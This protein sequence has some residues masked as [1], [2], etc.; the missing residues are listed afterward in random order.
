[1][2]LCSTRMRGGVYT[3]SFPC[4]AGYM[5]LQPREFL[6]GFHK[7]KLAK[8]EESKK[9]AQAREKEERL[10]ARREVHTSFLRLRFSPPTP[11]I[12]IQQRR[13]LAEQAAEN[14][15]KVEEA[16]GGFV[17]RKPNSGLSSHPSITFFSFPGSGNSHGSL[18]NLEIQTSNHGLASRR[19]L[20][21]QPISN[22]NVKRVYANTNSRTRSTSRPLPA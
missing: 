20:L 12:A 3:A 5:T 4:S 13:M 7:R 2:L 15:A 14:A 6:T 10:E 8:K 17:Q 21:Q 11:N 9:R 16:Y 22:V 1:M 18:K 19:G